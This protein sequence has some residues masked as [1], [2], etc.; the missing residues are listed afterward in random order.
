LSDAS[1]ENHR[2]TKVTAQQQMLLDLVEADS[3]A[4]VRHGRVTTIGDAPADMSVF[5]I[6]S[7]FG[8]ELP[9]L[10]HGNIPIFATDNLS[11]FVP[12]AAEIKDRAAGMLA[13]S[14]SDDV[15]AYLIW[16]RKEQIVHAT[17]AGN[18]E[19]E[20]RAA[21]ATGANPRASFAAWKA[22]IRNL[23]RPWVLE[24]VEIAYD[25]IGLIRSAEGAAPPR[26]TEP[27]PPAQS[28]LWPAPRPAAPLP[29]SLVPQSLAQQPHS[30]ASRRV[31]RVGQL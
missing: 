15:P 30:S 5:A 17:W 10:G 29:Q 1:A 20:A 3:A 26:A 8:R 11:Q 12:V 7:M 14:L 21:G 19:D 27:A 28:A 25:L 13:A 22:D 18:P 24:D 31:I 9:D 2:S 23:S 6:A 4:I 16:F